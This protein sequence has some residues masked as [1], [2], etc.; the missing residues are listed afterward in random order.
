MDAWTSSIKLMSGLYIISP[1]RGS[2][3]SA[4]NNLVVEIM[5]VCPDCP[6][7]KDACKERTR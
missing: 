7:K 4:C 3:K 1:T 6:C 5:P 2:R